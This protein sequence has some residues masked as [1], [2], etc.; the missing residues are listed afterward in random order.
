MSTRNIPSLQPTKPATVNEISSDQL[1]EAQAANAEKAPRVIPYTLLG[2][3]SWA[4]APS[5]ISEKTAN[6]LAVKLAKIKAGEKEEFVVLT[7]PNTFYGRIVASIAKI[8]ASIFGDKN[9]AFKIRENLVEKYDNLIAEQVLPQN[10]CNVAEENTFSVLEIKKIYDYAAL[11]FEQSKIDKTQT[12]HHTP[13]VSSSLE[14]KKNP[15]RIPESDDETGTS[16]STPRNRA[17]SHESG[18]HSRSLSSG[19]KHQKLKISGYAADSEDYDGDDNDDWL[20]HKILSKNQRL[21]LSQHV[22]TVDASHPKSTSNNPEF[23]DKGYD[24]DGDDSDDDEKQFPLKVKLKELYD[25]DDE[26]E[27]LLETRLQELRTYQK[28]EQ[29]DDFHSPDLFPVENP[30]DSTTTPDDFHSPNLFAVEN[31]KDDDSEGSMSRSRT[32]H[33][34]PLTSSYQEGS[35]PMIPVS[36]EKIS[37]MSAEEKKDTNL[38]QNITDQEALLKPVR[39]PEE[40]QH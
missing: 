16:N 2:W 20:P 5:Y 34:N 23:D 33:N 38:G 19:I 37:L 14:S 25:S 18:S 32:N 22:M 6:R 21:G 10:F 40:E 12:Q 11:L 36:E 27:F 7:A 24:A 9:M 29:L 28:R 35:D 3:G 4:Y 1:S 13:V 31:P 8:V 30:E 26:S 15:S 17:G 39:T